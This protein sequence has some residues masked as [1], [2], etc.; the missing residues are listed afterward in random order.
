MPATDPGVLCE[1]CV[2]SKAITKNIAHPRNVER[3]LELVSMDVMGP[4]HG[5]TKFMY[6]LII[7]DAYSGMT[8][9]QGLTNKCEASTEATWWFSEMK[10]ATHQEPSEI[11]LDHRIR[12][13]R[14]DQGEL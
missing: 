10:V 9:T 7:H 6:V 11:V 13:I 1:V 12:E 2:H 14:I 4:L 8:W 5:D 3:P